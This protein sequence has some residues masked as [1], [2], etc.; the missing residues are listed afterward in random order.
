MTRIIG[1]SGI[2]VDVDPSIADGLVEAGHARY[3]TEPVETVVAPPL[4]EESAGDGAAE[5]PKGNASL[6]EWAGYATAHG[7]DVTDLSRDE[8]RALF[9]E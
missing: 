4:V 6:D 5:K 3:V 7:K 1:P 9:K 2:E 8:I